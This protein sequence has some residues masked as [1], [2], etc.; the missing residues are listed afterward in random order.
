ML[1]EVKPHDPVVL[2]GIALLLGGS[3][4]VAALVPARRAATVDP[5]VVL[6]EE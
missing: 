5:L 2:G 3:A 4:I 1:Y 6:K